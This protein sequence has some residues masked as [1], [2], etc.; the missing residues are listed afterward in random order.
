MEDSDD[1]SSESSC[2][3]ASHV[4]SS[5]SSKSS[6][7]RAQSP[8]R[9][10]DIDQVIALKR[11]DS[12]L[13]EAEMSD[14]EVEDPQKELTDMEVDK[15]DV[16]P[17]KVDNDHDAASKRES[18]GKRSSGHVSSELPG[19]PEVDEGTGEIQMIELREPSLSRSFDSG[20]ESCT[21]SLSASSFDSHR[22]SSLSYEDSRRVSRLS[23]SF[24]MRKRLDT[25]SS[26][27]SEDCV[28][29]GGPKK[30]E[31]FSHSGSQD[32]VTFQ[33][34]RMLCLSD[35]EKEDGNIACTYTILLFYKLCTISISYN[36]I[37]IH[38]LKK[39]L[40]PGIT[41]YNKNEYINFLT[42]IFLT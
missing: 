1:E 2:S 30:R 13:E 39:K 9:M 18:F 34:D 23:S 31:R 5:C 17:S 41:T 12:G 10:M 28:F 40:R 29:S 35:E 16:K 24:E 6:S 42:W 33:I 21:S 7:E 3:E 36:V 22:K 25:W 27:G 11:R 15:R 4:S 26:T 19:V 37:R 20:R 32:S 14:E 8:N 38:C